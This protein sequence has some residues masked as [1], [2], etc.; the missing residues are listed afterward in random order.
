MLDKRLVEGYVKNIRA[1]FTSSLEKKTRLVLV[2]GGGNMSRLY[3]DFADSCGEDDEVDLHR[4]GITATWMNAELFRSLMDDIAYKRILGVGVYAEDQKEAE[5]LMAKDFESWL[6]SDVPVLVSGGFINGAS[7]DFNAALLASKIG[8]DRFFKLTDVDYVYD[9]DPREH[10][11]AKP[12]TDLSWDEF[13]RIFDVSFDN[14]EHKPGSHVPVDMFAA[15]LAHENEIGCYL[16]DG[17]DPGAMM[18]VLEQKEFEG[19]F[20]RR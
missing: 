17:T 16:G 11:D 12:L 3:R 14:P 4:I 10:E 19:T 18:R 1:Y 7:T 15:K 9:K 6:G 13:L 20:I 5:K 2:I 8:V